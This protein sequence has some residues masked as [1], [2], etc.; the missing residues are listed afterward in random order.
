MRRT[1]V[2][3][4][5]YVLVGGVAAGCGKRRVP[6]ALP[7]AP[8]PTV[9]E[10]PPPPPPAPELPPAGPAIMESEDEVFARKTLA[11]LNAERP[12]KDVFFAYDSDRL[13]EAELGVLHANAQWLERW[14]STRIL[15]EGHCDERGTAEYNLALG[16]RR[17]ARVKDYL[18]S[19]GIAPD[20]VATVSKG[21]EVPVCRE[22]HE[23]CWQQN[24]RGHAIITAK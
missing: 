3:I 10:P 21:E 6:Q 16:E 13:R 19:L 4:L 17:A 20:R 24:R 2:L 12:L 9:P 18:V 23:A 7:P 14:T 1:L 22:S 5:V 8:A 15:V 11:E